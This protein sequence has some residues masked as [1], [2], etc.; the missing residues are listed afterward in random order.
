MLLISLMTVTVQLLLPPNKIHTEQ[1][2]NLFSSLAV[3]NIF[4]SNQEVKNDIFFPPLSIFMIS[5]LI[6]AKLL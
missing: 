2:N 5:R 1:K 3:N 6:S 4:L